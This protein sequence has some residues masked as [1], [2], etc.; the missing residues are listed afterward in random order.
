MRI[1]P[2]CGPPLRPTRSPSQGLAHDLLAVVA[3]WRAPRRRDD[4]AALGATFGWKAG[5]TIR[6]DFSG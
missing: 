1:T 6:G 4:E 3:A 5:H 2:G